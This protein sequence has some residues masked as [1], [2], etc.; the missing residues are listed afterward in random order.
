MKG[1]GR[2]GWGNFSYNIIAHVYDS[3]EFIAESVGSITNED[4]GRNN[5]AKG[6][7]LDSGSQLEGIPYSR[8]WLCF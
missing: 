7:S 2:N 6:E 5:T 4:E 3:A 8:F 1:K